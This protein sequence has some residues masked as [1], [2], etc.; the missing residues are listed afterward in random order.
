[1]KS[2]E[3]ITVF[4]AEKPAP[5]S[6]SKRARKTDSR[7]PGG[8]LFKQIRPASK[9]DAPKPSI[10]WYVT[11]SS[12]SNFTIDGSLS[13]SKG[14]VGFEL[15]RSPVFEDTNRRTS[16][17]TV[18]VQATEKKMARVATAYPFLFRAL[19]RSIHRPFCQGKAISH[20]R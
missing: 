9:K 19:E 7:S 1:M 12:I 3:A 14:R 5:F 2:V 4:M 6:G 8:K 20:R 13:G 15:M 10:L 16:C 17:A 11:S 18:A